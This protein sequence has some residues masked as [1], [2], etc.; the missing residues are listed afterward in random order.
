MHISGLIAYLRATALPWYLEL[1]KPVARSRSQGTTWD[2]ST[3]QITS[4]LDSNFNET[5]QHDPLYDLTNSSAALLSSTTDGTWLNPITFDIPQNEGS[6]LRFYN[7]SDSIST[8]R[9][10]VRSA[11]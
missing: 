7:D 9:S 4:L 10:T 2:P 5:L 11:L 6:S 8:F 1:F 3:R